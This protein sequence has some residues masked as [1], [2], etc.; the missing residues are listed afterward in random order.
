MTEQGIFMET[1]AVRMIL[2]VVIVCHFLGSFF[3]DPTLFL[4][5]PVSALLF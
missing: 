1:L 4:S 5:Q 2:I 3:W